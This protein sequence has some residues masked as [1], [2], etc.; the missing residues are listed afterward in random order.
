MSDLTFYTIG[1]YDSTENDFFNKL[2]SNEIDTFVDIRRKRGVRGAKYA[3][4]NSKR[5]QKRLKDLKIN[6]HHELD[7]AP[8]KE[9]REKQKEADK[10]NNIKKRSRNKLG[11]VF[12]NEY[13]NKIL[14]EFDLK[15]F[16]QRL[17]NNKS[18]NVVLFCVE[19][20]PRACHRSLVTDKIKSLS[21]H[22]II[23]L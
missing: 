7:L 21:N 17:R 16:I 8:T 1:V 5:L 14:S 9:I 23:H 11:D 2:T 4:V 3:F 15:D 10:K 13:K 12:I 20:A 22:Q 18:K 19:S 6:Y